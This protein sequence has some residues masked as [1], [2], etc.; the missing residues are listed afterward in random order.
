MANNTCKVASFGACG[1]RVCKL[2]PTGIPNP[3][4]GNMYISGAPIEVKSTWQVKSGT[5]FE[6]RSG[7]G[8]VCTVVQ[9]QDDIQGLTLTMDLCQLDAE[10][11]AMLTGGTVITVGGNSLGF[12]DPPLGQQQQ[13][14]VCLDVWTQNQNGN[15]QDPN[16]PYIHW[17]YPRVTWRSGDATFNE[18]I[19]NV[20]FTGVAYENPN[21]EDGPFEDFN[22]NIT[23][24]RAWQL[25]T[26]IPV[27]LCGAQVL[28]HS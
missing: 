8:T 17:A 3:G 25:E 20:P 10:L 26:S 4:A 6:Q 19:L 22:V 12:I 11:M 14:G 16:Y 21:Y 15:S 24:I 23:T 2:G 7:C 1:I 28:P 13:N 5:R 27:P 9:E 18:G